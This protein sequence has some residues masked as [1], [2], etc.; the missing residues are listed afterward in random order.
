[1]TSAHVFHSTPEGSG[2]LAAEQWA[3]A[4]GLMRYQ[5][6]DVSSFL[7]PSLDALDA[8]FESDQPDA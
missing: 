8:P 2:I 7:D 4:H 3:S 5:R 1:M 6:V